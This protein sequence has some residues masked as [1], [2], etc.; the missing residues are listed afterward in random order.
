MTQGTE[1]RGY[2]FA[3]KAV[4]PSSGRTEELT[5]TVADGCVMAIS[6]FTDGTQ[7]RLWDI[8]GQQLDSL[9]GHLAV[10]MEEVA[11]AKQA[12]RANA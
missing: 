1:I 4:N 3:V 2:D 5:A 9:A 6:D 11:T 7:C 12:R 8:S 10:L